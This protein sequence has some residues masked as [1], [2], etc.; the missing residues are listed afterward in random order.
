M[1]YM[2]LPDGIET[3]WQNP[4]IVECRYSY[5]IVAL[6]YE[7][8]MRKIGGFLNQHNSTVMRVMKRIKHNLKKYE[9]TCEQIRKILASGNEQDVRDPQEELP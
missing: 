4:E 1:F 2:E 3:P 6:E 9:K 8:S 5:Y 7:Y